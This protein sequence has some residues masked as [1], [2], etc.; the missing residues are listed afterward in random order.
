MAETRR[1]FGRRG[2]RPSASTRFNEQVRRRVCLE[3]A[4]I[5]AEEGVRDYHFAK[6]KACARLNIRANSQ[7]PTNQEIEQ[8]LREYLQ[9]FHHDAL[10]RRLTRRYA[11]ALDTMDNLAPFAPR[12]V[13]S[14]ISGNVTEHSPVELHVFADGVEDVNLFLAEQGIP[15]ELTEKRLRFGGDRYMNLPVCRFS[16]DGIVIEMV[17][18]A[19]RNLKE[20]PLDPTDSR[21]MRRMGMK[22]LEGLAGAHGDKEFSI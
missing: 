22:E 15:C 9:L 14:L 11:L 13:G 18:F 10:T 3:C 12:L 5:M 16:A 7:L 17:V 2:I 1:R 4:R 19:P 21:P 8:A 6:R 20:P